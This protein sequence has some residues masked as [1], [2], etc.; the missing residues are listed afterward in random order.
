MLLAQTATA[1]G[2]HKKHFP[3][4]VVANDC[5]RAVRTRHQSR[6]QTEASTDALG[7]PHLQGPL[8]AS[9]QQLVA[10]LMGEL[11]MQ[12]RGSV[13]ELSLPGYHEAA[14]RLDHSV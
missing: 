3:L 11:Q 4:E 7:R 12:D 6:S 8:V 14:C 5:S 1:T 2:G 9:V 13:A 10:L